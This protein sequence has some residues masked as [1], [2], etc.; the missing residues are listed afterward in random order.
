[1]LPVAVWVA[2]DIPHSDDEIRKSVA[3]RFPEAQTALQRSSKPWDVED[4]ELARQIKAEYN[5]LTT[6][7][8]AQR[9]VPMMAHL[10]QQGIDVTSYGALPSVAGWMTKRQILDSAKRS[11]VGMIYLIEEQGKPAMDVA[12]ATN[13][14][15]TVWSRGITGTDVKIAVLDNTFA[16]N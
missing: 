7:D 2:S 12:A 6:A 11:D 10:K 13:L 14:A 4:L 1:M 8:T 15:P 5:R 9:I 3:A 16:K